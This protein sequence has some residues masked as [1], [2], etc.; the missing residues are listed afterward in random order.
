M[1]PLQVW[2][3][4]SSSCSYTMERLHTS[5]VRALT[6]LARDSSPLPSSFATASSDGTVKVWDSRM[7]SSGNGV[8]RSVATGSTNARL[9][10]LCAVTPLIRG[11]APPGDVK[12]KKRVAHQQEEMATRQQQK[13][14]PPLLQKIQQ[15]QQK[16]QQQEIVHQGKASKGG[17]KQGT[18]RPKSAEPSSLPG[19]HTHGG[20]IR[21]SGKKLGK[22]KTDAGS[23]LTASKIKPI[24]RPMKQKAG[25]GKRAG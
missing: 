5:R 1:V 15:R 14:Q 21:S 22:S 7:L 17:N 6:L 12:L 13:P 20:V 2:D 4:R 9:T 8:A 19:K 18:E 10:C 16:Q 24:A 11:S 23:K 3:V 25:V